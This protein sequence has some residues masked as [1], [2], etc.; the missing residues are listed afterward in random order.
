M[1][2]LKYFFRDQKPEIL[3]LGAGIYVFPRYTDQYIYCRYLFKTSWGNALFGDSDLSK[4]QISFAKSIGGLHWI[5]PTQYRSRSKKKD[6]HLFK[7]FGARWVGTDIEKE[8]EHI[9]IGE[10]YFSDLSIK[11]QKLVDKQY[12]IWTLEY[13]KESFTLVEES[14][15]LKSTSTTLPIKVKKLVF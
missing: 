10:P 14:F 2:F 11:D 15:E 4:K 7:L 5:Y 3:K 8:W 9:P 6:L 1:L 13:K 12:L